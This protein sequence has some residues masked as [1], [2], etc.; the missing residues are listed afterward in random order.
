MTSAA[1]LPSTVVLREAV[2]P[3]TL[4]RAGGSDAPAIGDRFLL[5][6]AA[7]LRRLSQMARPSST[8]V[9]RR[10]TFAMPTP[11]PPIEVTSEVQMALAAAASRRRSRSLLETQ[12]ESTQS[13]ATLDN[14]PSEADNVQALVEPQQVKEN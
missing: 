10:S 11:P 9:K 14:G 2:C 7:S 13:T 4:P 1:L 12:Q 3:K 6:G 5:D 8:H